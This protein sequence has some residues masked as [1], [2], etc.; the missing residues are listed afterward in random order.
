MNSGF[1]RQYQVREC[2]DFGRLF[3][4]EHRQDPR[5][6][7]AAVSGILQSDC[8]TGLKAIYI[9]SMDVSLAEVGDLLGDTDRRSAEAVEAD[10][11]WLRAM[12]DGLQKADL[13]VD[14]M[15]ADDHIKKIVE[16]AARP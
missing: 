12:L 13:P 9:A 2:M 3:E 14:P 5:L 4:V 10:Q 7:A 11:F 6:I 16:I 15:A 8:Q 1:D